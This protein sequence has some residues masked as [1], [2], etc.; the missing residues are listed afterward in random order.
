MTDDEIRKLAREV[1]TET[2][3]RLGLDPNNPD[4][5]TDVHD[6]KGLLGAWR[7]AKRTIGQTITRMITVAIL[8][9][10]AVG[11]AMQIRGG[12]GE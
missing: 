5:V 6:L 1:V 12:G 7:S 11:A 2:L 10:L 9:A 3:D 4:T 8:G